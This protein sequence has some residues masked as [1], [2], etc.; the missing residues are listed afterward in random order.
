[1]NQRAFCLVQKQD[2]FLGKAGA[3]KDREKLQVLLEHWVEHNAAHEEEFEKWAQ[4]A[5][6]AGLEEVCREISGAADRLQEATRCLREALSHLG[7]GSEG[8]EHVP[9]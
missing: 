4:R 6:Q 9:E 1:M 5:R 2:V 7:P 8:G 3:M